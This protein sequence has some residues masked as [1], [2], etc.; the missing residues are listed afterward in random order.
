[1]DAFYKLVGPETLNGV[2]E[3]FEKTFRDASLSQ[4]SN[5][6][7]G[8]ALV[9]VRLGQMLEMQIAI[10][11]KLMLRL[12]ELEDKTIKKPFSKK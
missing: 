2:L 9:N 12:D 7:I 8:L 11:R 1:M 10:N 4:T 6:D 5:T 3:D